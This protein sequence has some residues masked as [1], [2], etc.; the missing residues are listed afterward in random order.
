MVELSEEF[1]TAFVETSKQATNLIAVN[2]AK[3]KI[4]NVITNKI[5]NYDYEKVLISIIK[6][7]CPC[8]QSQSS[9][10]KKMFLTKLN[11][12]IETHTAELSNKFLYNADDDKI[13]DNALIC[14]NNNE[15]P[16]SLPTHSAPP[17]PVAIKTKSVVV[18]Q[19]GGAEPEELEEKCKKII[20][21]VTTNIIEK[22]DKMKFTDDSEY[23]TEIDN[24][25]QALIDKMFNENDELKDVIELLKPLS[26][27]C[28][29]KVNDIREKQYTIITKACKESIVT[30]TDFLIKTYN[31]KTTII[32]QL[33]GTIQDTIANQLF[34]LMT[35]LIKTSTTENNFIKNNKIIKG[36]I[37]NLQKTFGERSNQS[38]LESKSNYEFKKNSIFDNNYNKL[39]AI[40]KERAILLKIQSGGSKT[41]SKRTTQNQGRK[42]MI[43]NKT[44][45]H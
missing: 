17:F 10:Y 16:S 44:R 7:I 23:K 27:D 25:M 28:S 3:E 20:D 38:N 42:R 31:N 26:T 18:K 43:L 6:N 30:L 19:D 2:E 29:N 34:E 41:I 8:I 14:G 9:E 36:N 40:I 12:Y 32:S 13:R 35:T 24:A 21:S 4:F 22:F 15:K 5:T 11:T 45:K 39:T 33:F 1:A 37:S